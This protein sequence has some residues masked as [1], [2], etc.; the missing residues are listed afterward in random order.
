MKI[1]K[2]KEEEKLEN[3]LR[4]SDIENILNDFA[5]LEHQI[6]AEEGETANSFIN[7]MVT[8][9][10]NA[11]YTRVRDL[12]RQRKTEKEIEF[13]SAQARD[14]AETPRYYRPLRRLFRLTPNEAM[15]QINTNAEQTARLKHMQQ[16][17]R[18]DN[19]KALA[20]E[21]EERY[22]NGQPINF[23]EDLEK[24]EDGF[25][26]EEEPDE[27][28]EA[29]EVE[30]PDEEGENE[31]AEV[32][33]TLPERRRRAKPAEAPENDGEQITGQVT[34][35]EA[36]EMPSEDDGDDNDEE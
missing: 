28:E 1:R 9:V 13:A 27:V 23:E 36:I 35:D 31:G 15:E 29:D 8:L 21:W 22:E 5:P 12:S 6:K 32:V 18:N 34:I 19:L 16:K 30:E 3:Y 20:D 14:N 11:I 24:L 7:L 4:P 2:C 17:V 10:E 26:E 33:P 25:E